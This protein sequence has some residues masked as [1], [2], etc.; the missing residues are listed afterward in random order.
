MKPILRLLALSVSFLMIL[1]SCVKE[2]TGLNVNNIPGRATI[3]GKLM[4]DKG[5]T[6]E[7]GKYVNMLVPAA[8]CQLVIKL[9]NADLSPSGNS[10]GYTDFNVTTGQD[11]SF[12]ISVPA[13]DSGVSYEVVGTPFINPFFSI[14]NKSD[15]NENIIVEEHKAIY[16][17]SYEGTLYLKPGSIE[18]VDGTYESKVCSDEVKE[19]KYYDLNIAVGLGLPSPSENPTSS[20][21]NYN[22]RIVP[23]EGIDVQV[24]INGKKYLG[25]SDSSGHIKL[26]LPCYDVSE[27]NYQRISLNISEFLGTEDFIYYTRKNN[28]ITQKYSEA[29]GKINAGS[30][31]LGI[32]DS[33]VRDD[34]YNFTFFTPTIKVV[35][36]LQD[37][38]NGADKGILTRI[39]NDETN[40]MMYTEYYVDVI[41]KYRKFWTVEN[42]IID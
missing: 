42:F 13:V 17:Y 23:A 22:G 12:Q 21:Y 35:I 37:I 19:I 11:G 8:N 39:D 4:L 38:E 7:N 1:S 10:K 15:E 5:T 27:L 26:S 30:Y 24:T 14:S 41:H 31:T 6:Y 9:K 25:V 28:I 2:Q 18:V 40:D 29:S 33:D 34:G 20:S 32:F 16:R 36:A 3:M